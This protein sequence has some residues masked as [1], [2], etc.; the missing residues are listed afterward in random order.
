MTTH[1]CLELRSTIQL[2]D[3][4]IRQLSLEHLAKALLY[5]GVAVQQN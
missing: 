1:S 5:T 3:N 4:Y 2:H